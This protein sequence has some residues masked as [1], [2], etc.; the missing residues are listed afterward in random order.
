ME[1]IIIW[2]IAGA[3]IGGLFTLITHRRRSILLL[4]IIV[5]SIGAC[6][7]GYLLSPMFHINTT[8]FGLPGLLVAMVGTI[9]LLAI[10]NFFVREHTVSNT[11]MEDQ[12]SQVSDK[13]QTRWNKITEE[14]S[15]QINGNHDRFINLIEE[16]Y[17]ITKEKAEEQLQGFLRAVTTKVP[18]LSFL[19]KRE[20]DVNPSHDH[21]H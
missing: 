2:L 4:N 21:N 8:S 5:G 10:V 11:V 18:W 9:V 1:N 20:R 6:V 19:H 12:W 16:R 17:G 3:V 13:I 14:D 15:D 7:A